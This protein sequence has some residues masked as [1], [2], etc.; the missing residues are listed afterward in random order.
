MLHQ[1]LR[2]RR[3]E[4]VTQPS[5]SQP[6]PAPTG[7]LNI[8]AA[9]GS[10]AAAPGTLT[11]NTVAFGA[12][13]GLLVFNHT[14]PYYVF[15]PAITGCGTI[16]VLAGNTIL[17]GDMSGF[18][19]TMN[20]SAGAD[21][22]TMAAQQ[23]SLQSLAADQ[24]AMAAE[25]HAT[26]GELLGMTRPVDNSRFIDY[27]AMFGSAVAY[28]GGQYADRGVTVLGGIAYGA[29]DYR[30]I[31]QGD[32]PTVAAAMRYTF[33]DVFG[34]KGRV[35]TPY[36]EIGGWITPQ[37]TLTLNRTY[38]NGNTLALGQGSSNETSWA[39][40]GR[41]GL[42]WNATKDD[43]LTGYG[44]LGQQYMSF[45]GY[46]ENSN[47][48]NP[49]P[50]SVGS[51]L[52]RMGVARIG[53]SWTH[54]LLHLIEAPISFTLAGDAAR[55]FNVHSGLGATFLGAASTDAADIT[56]TWG[57][58]G[59]RIEARFTDR[60]ALDLDLNGTTNGALGTVLHGGIGVTVEF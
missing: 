52:F 31:R 59:A 55:S 30:N 23:T 17:A 40:Y 48:G 47:A 34:E 25:S 42:V 43:Q 33:D 58:F 54:D 15:T 19:G 21:L 32:A 13:T 60:L 7:T 9:A 38:M 36:V 57:E 10:P 3:H 12:G 44:E 20:I 22:T 24:Q 14:S 5:I 50:A 1:C 49:F 18:C 41:G 53:G 51:G 11:A 35:L 26:A 46:T 6:T 2:R 56:D 37:A 39:E 8:G 29:Q 28:A 16:E 4:Q 27:G 45:D